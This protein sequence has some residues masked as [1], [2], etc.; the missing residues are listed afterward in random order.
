MKVL[1]TGA[2]GYIGGRLVT[3]LLEQGFDVRCMARD[4]SRLDQHP[5]RDRVE[6]VRGDVLDRESLNGAL[7]GC[8]SAVYLVHS[9]DGASV[10]FA[11]RDRTGAANFREAAADNNLSRIVYLGGLGDG[12]DLSEHL[13]SRQEVGRLLAEGPTPVTEVRAA[14]IIGSGS[15]SFEMMRYLTEV[16]PVMVTPR[17]V[18]TR[19]QPIAIRNVLEVLA[20]AVADEGPD[21]HVW[22]IGG[23]DQLTYEEMMRRY[24]VQAGLRR[25]WII[26]VPLLS[27]QLSRH[28]IG[29]VTPIPPGVAKPLVNSLRNEVVVRDND[30]AERLVERLIPFD[31]AVRRALD[32]SSDGNVVTRWSDAAASPAMAQP[33]DPDWAGGTLQFD[34]RRVDTSASP[35]DLYWAFARIGGDAG[36]YAFDWAWKLRGLVDRLVGGVG[37]RRGRRHPTDLRPGEALDFWRVALVERGRRLQLAAEMKLPGEAWLEFEALPTPEGSRLRQTAYFRPRGLLGRL[38]W[39][40]LVPAHALIFERMARRI[41]STA[42]DRTAAHRSGTGA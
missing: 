33:S 38:Y 39:L 30:V 21:G 41:A 17:W 13:A 37:L 10:G 28:W 9:M 40:V 23:P 22:E 19:C 35:D 20:A 5:W 3:A 42:E 25:R 11:E 31:E 7:A 16:L 1:L 15:V 36:Y 2:T 32:R 6:V 14:V 26:P 12:D 29:L 8:D 24:A 27:P 4:P 18:R 34:E